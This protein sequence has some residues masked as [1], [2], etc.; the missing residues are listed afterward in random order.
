MSENGGILEN[1][2]FFILYSSFTILD[3]I[4]G[5][6]ESL[7]EIGFFGVNGNTAIEALGPC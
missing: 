4:L 2:A 1:R 7:P 6:G 5:V 3:S